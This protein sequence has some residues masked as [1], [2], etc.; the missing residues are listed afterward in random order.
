MTIPDDDPLN[1]H[2]D[3]E[4]AGASKNAALQPRYSGSGK[5]IRV[6]MYMHDTLGL[7]RL[8]RHLK[9]ARALKSAYPDLGIM[10][11]SGSPQAEEF[12]LPTGV[13]LIRL[14][15][16][17]K[18]GD[19]RYEARL[20]GLST[21]ETIQK[22]LE[23]LINAVGAYSPHI[24]IADHSHLSMNSEI[25]P[26]LEYLREKFPR[27][28]RILGM[29]GII[30]EPSK[31][32]RSWEEQKIYDVL[33]DL[34]DHIFIYTTPIFYNPMSAY[35][36]TDDIR[37]KVYF[38]GCV[39][40]QDDADSVSA[41]GNLTSSGGEKLV[42]VTIG[43]G[44]YWGE[45]VIGNFLKALRN[46]IADLTFKSLVL[47]GPFIP[48]DLWKKFNN[49]SLGLPV[50]IIKFTPDTR[51]YLKQSSLVVSTGGYNTVTDILAHASRAIIIP[52][53]KYRTEQLIRAQR[54]S[55]LGLVKLVHPDNVTPESIYQ[56]IIDSLE[57]TSEPLVVARSRGELQLNG[58]R[59]VVKILGGMFAE[60]ENFKE[61][62]S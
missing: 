61:I 24:F 31:V 10:L 7:G 41:S 53:I 25:I 48:D 45:I 27:C 56:N 15:S 32:I 30:D 43:G 1:S 14:P 6:M 18:T 57:E 9:I 52:R 20:T 13:E 44:E 5:G 51:P 59:H 38:C 47:T 55:Y 26:C 40:D 11:V 62:S 42:M 58:T 28:R 39:V 33:R 34:Y 29:R 3:S 35:R 21:E 37:R 16:L 46:N 50:E 4:F 60:F 23:I 12:N 8:R 2:F 19:G 54:L 36:L 22:R 49:D 17:R